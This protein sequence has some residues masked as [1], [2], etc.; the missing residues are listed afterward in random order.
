MQPTGIRFRVQPSYPLDALNLC[1]ILTGH[2]FYTSRHPVEWEWW[3]DRMSST[4]HAA[5]AK[6]QAVHG[7]HM[8]GPILTLLVSAVPDFQRRPLAELLAGTELIHAYYRH[9]PYYDSSTW[10]Q[11]AELLQTI[12]PVIA[13]LED[14]GLRERWRAHHLPQVEADVA[15]LN[16]VLTA[17]EHNL[18]QA[19]AD[20]LGRG[21]PG[22]GEDIQVYICAYAAPHGIKLCGRQFITQTG[23]ESRRNLQIAIHEMFHPP[24]DAAALGEELARLIADPLFQDCWRRKDA[25]FGYATEL[26]FLE[27]NVVE[28]MTV[29]LGERFGIVEDPVGYLVQREGDVYRLAVVLY[30]VMRRHPKRDSSEPFASY[31]RRLI[32]LM[33]VGNLTECFQQVWKDWKAVR[34]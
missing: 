32:K 11:H 7:S 12:A 21:A 31:F 33:D 23:L 8:L 3:R 19:I 9:Y 4:V 34:G 1:S 15:R 13:D 17:C 18:G 27:E 2:P 20:M 6:A 28:A 24:Y 25:A 22:V 16:A 14:R 26:G 5:L 30:E 29:T 10:A